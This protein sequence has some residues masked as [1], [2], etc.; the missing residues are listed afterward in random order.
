MEIEIGK[1]LLSVI[2]WSLIIISVK[3]AGS[4]IVFLIEFGSKDDKE[5]NTNP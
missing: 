4:A 5:N 1:N 2:N 3:I